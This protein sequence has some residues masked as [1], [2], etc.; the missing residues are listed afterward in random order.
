MASVQELK[1]ALALEQAK[2][3]ELSE[4]A[5]Q[6]IDT[7]ANN[8]NFWLTVLSIEI[9]LIALVGFGAIYLG[10]IK[11]A[12]KVA[13]GRLDAYIRGDEVGKRVR[14][15]ITEEVKVQ[16]ERRSFVVVHPTPHQNG[17]GSFPTAPSSDGGKSP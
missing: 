15:E 16:I 9:G 7:I 1:D 17:E 5:F 10:S 11:A 3:A 8:A 2:A 4:R 14:E 12:T 6:A 13:N